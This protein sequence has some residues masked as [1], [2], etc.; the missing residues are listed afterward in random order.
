[1]Y[2]LILV[3]PYQLMLGQY[4]TLGEAETAAA[5]AALAVGSCEAWIFNPSGAR[6][7]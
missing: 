4:E 2:T 3:K 1:M 6:V 5:T 7:L